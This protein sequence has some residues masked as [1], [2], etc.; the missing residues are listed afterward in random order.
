MMALM[1]MIKKRLTAK[2]DKAEMAWQATIL[3]LFPDMF[4]GPLGLSLAGRALEQDIWNLH[5][6]QIR[7]FATDKHH[8]V[9]DTPLGG[10]AG[11]VLKPNVVSDAL[12]SV[13]DAPGPRLFLAAGASVGSKLVRE[14]AAGPGAVMVC[15]RY[16]GWINGS[17]II[18]S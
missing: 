11:M 17:L 10:G 7:D 4:P 2:K 3:S 9:D 14:L 8:M 18:I 15:G 16:G 6:V 12:S 5:K 13:A 1:V